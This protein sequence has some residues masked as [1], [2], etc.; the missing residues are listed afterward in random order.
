M[1]KLKGISEEGFSR[2]AQTVKVADWDKELFTAP[3]S[4]KQRDL[5]EGVHEVEEPAEPSKS[6]GTD[7][8]V[9]QNVASVREALTK[10]VTD[11]GIG[12]GGMSND[13]LGNFVT[14]IFDALYELEIYLGVAEGFEDDS[15]P[16]DDFL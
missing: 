16:D 3:K 5:P 1:N 4:P 6:D 11:W 10:L 7:A 2:L 13:V 9:I 14:P 15:P 12:G 8:L